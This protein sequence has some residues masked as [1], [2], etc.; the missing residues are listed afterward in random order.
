[1]IGLGSDKNIPSLVLK[2][3]TKLLNLSFQ[4]W[5]K[6]L[7]TRST[8]S[9]SATQQVLSWHPLT[10]GSHHSSL[11]NG[12]ESVSQ[13]VSQSFSDKHCQW[14]DSVPIKNNWITAKA[15]VWDFTLGGCDCLVFARW[16][17]RGGVVTDTRFQ[18]VQ[19]K[20]WKKDFYVFIVKT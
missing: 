14:S 2:V 7:P 13:S 10:P 20:N 17:R 1:M 12:S 6:L 18:Q 19:R 5:N 16:W 9:T 8:S 15:I 3:W 4:I 11:L